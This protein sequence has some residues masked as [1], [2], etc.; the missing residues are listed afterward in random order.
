[1][2]V[3]SGTCLSWFHSYLSNRRQSAAIANRISPTK[4]L[5]YSVQHG[6]VLWP[7]SFVLCIQPLSNLIKRHSLSVH[8]FADDIPIETQHLHRAI[9]SVETCISDVKYWMIE[10]KLQLSDVK[11]ECL[12]IRPNNS[13]HN[14][15]CTFLSLRHN[16]MSFST[17]AK[18]LGYK[19]TDDI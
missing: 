17:T 6:S 14:L 7:I 13:T 16:V 19:H 3:I 1:M 5:H 9:S 8:L 2:Y 12:P 10:N 11:T 15:H 4:E 18:N